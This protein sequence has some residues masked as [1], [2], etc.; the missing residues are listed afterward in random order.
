MAT[1]AGSI[2]HGEADD[3][4]AVDELRA[5]FATTSEALHAALGTA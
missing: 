1:L 2:E 5:T 3:A 4:N